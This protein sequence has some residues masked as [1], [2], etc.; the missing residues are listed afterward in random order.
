MF[1]KCDII[2][3][4]DH[5]YYTQPQPL[6]ASVVI[7][8]LSG[9]FVTKD[10]SGNLAL[11]AAADTQIHGW[12]DVGTGDGTFTAS[13]TAG[14]TKVPIVRDLQVVFEIPNKTG[15]TLTEATLKTLMFKTC[16]LYVDSGIQQADTTA[17]TTDVLVIVGGDVAKNWLYVMINPAKFYTAGV[18]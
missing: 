1:L 15:Q 14:D 3:P 4:N 9:K 2:Y 7:K 6:A 8:A 5:T 16:D 10:G 12:A 13:A 18:V 11:S 17:S